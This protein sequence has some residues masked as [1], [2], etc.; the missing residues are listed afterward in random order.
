MDISTWFLL[1]DTTQI[2]TAVAAPA[3]DGGHGSGG[4][5]GGAALALFQ[6]ILIDLVLAGDNAVAVGLAAAGLAAGM[7]AKVIFW[8]VAA[9]VVMRIAFALVATRLLAVPGL[10]LAGGLLLIWVAWK[11][12]RE[13]SI[14]ANESQ[15]MVPGD[16]PISETAPKTWG[17]AFRQILIADLSMSLDN[18]LGV[19]AAAREHPVIM[20]FGLVLSVA[21]MGW[22]ATW[23]ANALHK[24]RWIGWAGLVVIIIVALKMTWEGAEQLL[25]LIPG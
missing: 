9:A 25:H 8:G 17:A 22:G 10:L 7:R 5:T 14:A 2:V 6:V 11:L 24:H 1:A 15:S 19:A 13:L 21:L 23:I 16:H 12:W 18:V 3:A 4:L 20:A